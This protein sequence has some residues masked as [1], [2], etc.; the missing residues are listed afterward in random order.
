M[1]FP[2]TWWIRAHTGGWLPDVS[3]FLRL[4]EPKFDIKVDEVCSKLNLKAATGNKPY[5]HD[6]I[7]L[8]NKLEDQKFEIDS[9][10][11]KNKTK[12]ENIFYLSQQLD[13]MNEDF[14]KQASKL[15]ENEDF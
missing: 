1:R 7:S 11:K 5:K 8:I 4:C 12:D 14:M 6:K 9:L 15:K 13:Q 10:T 3:P 2:F